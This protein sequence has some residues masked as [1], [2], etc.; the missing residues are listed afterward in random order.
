MT[1]Q[2]APVRVAVIQAASV[3]FDR[4]ATL[5]KACQL[6]RDAGN[7]SAQLVLFPEALIPG[8]PRGLSFGMVVGSRTQEGREIWRQ[9]WENAV[10]IPSSATDALGEAAR[11]AGVYSA[12][13]VIERDSQGGKGTLYCTLLYFSQQG[14]IIGKHRKLKPTGSER[15][16]W[17]EGDGSTLPVFPTEIGNI[18]GLICW[19]NYM[20]LARMAMYSKGVELYLAPTA[21]QRDTWQA[22]MRH[23]A[24]EGRCFVLGC[25][26]FVTKDMYPQ[27]FQDHPELDGQPEV[28][29][30]GGS[31]I[32]SPLGEVLAGPL[33]DQEGILYADLDM[34]EIA[35]AKLDF[36][37]VGHY[38]RPD[39]FQLNINEQPM[40]S[41]KWTSL[42]GENLP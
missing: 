15:L 8:Y 14:K 39:V 28:M 26:Q 21:D 13:G 34:N 19:E 24:C 7:N 25:N 40:P 41:V 38:A 31:V 37:V 36:D 16:I 32:I 18:G 11:E 10:D 29:C 3:L 6:I 27:S 42:E 2:P 23:I 35:R 20:P 22:T 9:Y 1:K 4:Q 33:Y 30:R 17:G 5:E 12:I